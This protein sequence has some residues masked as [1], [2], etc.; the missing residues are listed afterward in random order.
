MS[1]GSPA[2]KRA[3]ERLA[4]GTAAVLLVA[5]YLL[6]F[7]LRAPSQRAA[8]AVAVAESSTLQR[9]HPSDTR[10]VPNHC[11][12]GIYVFTPRG[13]AGGWQHPPVVGSQLLLL[14]VLTCV[15]CS[16]ALN[17]SNR[18]ILYNILICFM[19][20]SAGVFYKQFV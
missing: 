14:L 2:Q 10:S 15:V 9:Q 7:V 17:W 8:L 6:S 18:F 4:L 19:T 5:G 13:P 20:R 3:L 16:G 1:L 12:T 11:P